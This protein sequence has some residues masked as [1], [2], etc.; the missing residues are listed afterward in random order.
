MTASLLKYNIRLQH[1]QGFTAAWSVITLLYILCFHF[2]PEEIVRFALPIGLFS[3]PSTFAMIFTGAIVLLERDEGLLENLFITPMTIRSYMVSKSLALSLPACLSTMTITLLVTGPALRILLL[4]PSVVL[5]TLFFSLLGFVCASGS[6]D[7]MGLFYRITLFGTPFSIPLLGY[8]G[9]FPGP[10][11]Y[12]L[13]S[14]GTLDLT[15]MAAGSAPVTI[16]W[17]ALLSLTAGTALLLPLAERAFTRNLLEKGALK[18]GS[19]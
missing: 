16:P 4:I 13:V 7:I 18:G 10:W 11:Y 17:P 9:L 5:T 12:L 6:G 3:E 15:S 8:F 14:R 1:R 2:L 19:L